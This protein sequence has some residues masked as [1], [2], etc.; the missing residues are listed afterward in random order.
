MGDMPTKDE[1]KE[2]FKGRQAI[3]KK[4]MQEERVQKNSEKA[5]R[6]SS[7]KEAAV[8]RGEAEEEV[9]TPKKE[10]DEYE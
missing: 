3:L 10:I 9:E 7:R 6:M 4:N 1:V 5:K 2:Q 8:M